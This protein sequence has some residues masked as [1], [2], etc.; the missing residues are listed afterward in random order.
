MQKWR[1]VGGGP[2]YQ[3]FNGRAVYTDDNLDAW[4]DEKIS[5]PRRSTSDDLPGQR[6]LVAALG[7]ASAVAVESAD[8]EPKNSS[9]EQEDPE[10]A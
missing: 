8:A 10:A 1:S 3:I 9:A 7:D 4:V 2:I 5:S 6:K